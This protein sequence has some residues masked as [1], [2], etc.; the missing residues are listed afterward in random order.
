MPV[1]ATAATMQFYQ[2]PSGQVIQIVHASSTPNVV[3]HSA[4]PAQTAA[5]PLGQP[6]NIV[7]TT[8]A[9]IPAIASAC[10]V[11]TPT[12]QVVYQLSNQ[13]HNILSTGTVGSGT[14][15][16][17]FYQPQMQPQTP[18]QQ[19]VLVASS[20]CSTPTIMGTVIGSGT[21]VPPV[22]PV[23][24][25]A[26]PSISNVQQAQI[27]LGSTGS[28]PSTG[29]PALAQ[30]GLVTTTTPTL[31]Q[32]QLHPGVAVAAVGASHIVQPSGPTLGACPQDYTSQVQPQYQLVQQ[33]PQNQ[34]IAPNVMASVSVVPGTQFMQSQPQTIP[35]QPQTGRPSSPIF[36]SV[37]PRTSRVLHSEIY[38]RYINR[39]RKNTPSGGGLGDWHNQLSASLDTTPSIQPNVANQLIGNFF[40]D[41]KKVQSCSVT[42]ALWNL[43]DYLLEDAL[44]IRLRCLNATEC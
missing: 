18:Q 24:T 30:G 41:P 38:Q 7:Q 34:P 9:T 22:L 36:V 28:V 11:A 31:N 21:T 2:T 35:T 20:V 1:T 32:P 23:G 33:V 13:Q 27:L 15:Q 43:R 16:Q 37:P 6:A 25:N 26:G 40:T 4:V 8:Y 17:P 19:R 39:L 10:P 42:E 44:K 29:F 12:H 5:A 14:P 3:G